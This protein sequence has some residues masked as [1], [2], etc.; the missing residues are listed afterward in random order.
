VLAEIRLAAQAGPDPRLARKRAAKQNSFGTLSPS[1]DFLYRMTEH[2]AL[3]FLKA[4]SRMA[5][6]AIE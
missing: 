6:T 1:R 5:A 4:R 3:T 2:C